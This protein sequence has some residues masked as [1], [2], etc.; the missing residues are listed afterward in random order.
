[1]TTW[2]PKTTRTHGNRQDLLNFQHDLSS[3]L[4]SM[5][6][7]IATPIPLRLRLWFG[8]RLYGPLGL[9]VVRVSLDRIIK[10]TC[11]PEE[12]EGLYFIANNTSIPIPRLHKIHTPR[13]DD[14]Y[15]EIEY[16]YGEALDKVWDT[17]GRL[18]LSQKSTIFAGLQEFIA[19][20][21]E[22][23]PPEDGLVGSAYGNPVYDARGGL[24][25][26]VLSVIVTSIR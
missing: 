13:I 23:D 1:M 9:G 4:E 25:S 22:L 26:S 12:V 20:L 21:R 8:R 15:M 11:G 18:S 19:M 5:G 7:S 14:I 6:Q 24:V 2:T 3:I 16:V 17:N 10:G